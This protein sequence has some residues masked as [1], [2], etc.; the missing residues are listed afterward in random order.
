MAPPALASSEPT[1]VSSTAAG[2]EPA[3]G[4]PFASRASVLRLAIMDAVTQDD[5]RGLTRRLVAE[6]LAGDKASVRLLWQYA[7]GK[8]GPA[9][10]PDRLAYEE[11]RAQ[12]E[13]ALPLGQFV[14]ATGD[15]PGWLRT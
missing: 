13:A 8:P 3:P 9:P 7:I 2:R 5:V 1:P 12:Q 15:L 11:W 6:G 4:R 14:Q 10:D